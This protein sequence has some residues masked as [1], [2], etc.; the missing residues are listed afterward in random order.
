MGIFQNW[1]DGF[2]PAETADF[3]KDPSYGGEFDEHFDKKP[4]ILGD[5]EYANAARTVDTPDGGVAYVPEKTPLKRRLDGRHIQFIALGGGIGTGL[6]IGS[7][8]SLTTAG[9]AFMIVDFLIMGVMLMCVIYAL[10]ELACVLPVSGAFSTYASRFIDPAWGFAVGWNYYLQWLIV[11]PL[12]FTAAAIVIGFWD[13]EQKVPIGIWIMIFFL[14]ITFINM[15]GVRGYAEFEFIATFIKLFTVIGLIITLIV[16]DCGGVVG[17]PGYLGTH[18]WWDPGAINNGFKG[19]CTVFTT[20]AFAFS[21]SELVGLAA[22]ETKQP[23][24]VLPKAAKQIVLRIIFF[25]VLSLFLVSLI[26]PFNDP[27]LTSGHNYDPHTSPFVIALKIGRVKVLPHIVNAVIIISTLSVA[28][29]GVYASSRTLLALAEQGF[30]PRL[31]KYVDREGRPL[32][33]VAISLLFGV[34]AFLV[35]SSN[36]GVVFSWLLQISGLAAIFTWGSICMCHVRFRAAWKK[37]GNSLSELPWA[38]PLG[39]YGSFLGLF[40]N[41]L[42]IAANI[43]IGAF[44]LDEAK[45]SPN[46][47]AYNFFNSNISLVVILFF[48]LCYK[49]IKRTRIVRLM[50]MDIH[51]GRRDPVSVEV[52]EQERAEARARPFW[53]RMISTVF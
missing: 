32:I 30:A 36:E 51:T 41:V 15:F 18:T 6:F 5:E 26:V 22:A 42:V 3:G 49:L 9:P 29:S 2:K 10:G 33:A 39:V 1:V 11:T 7:A 46:E 34:L 24:K 17:G 53:K 40:L 23:R 16:I 4:E 52:L 44:D 45:E 21:G 37:Q 19:F 35:Y 12:E 47:R 13:P 43:Y 50:D 48:F 14:V 31:F 20:A 27:R 8:A 38:S 28:N 25:Y